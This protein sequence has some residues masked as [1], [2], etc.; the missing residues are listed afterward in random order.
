MLAI[1]KI[2]KHD[3]HIACLTSYAPPQIPMQTHKAGESTKFSQYLS[4]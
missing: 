1:L 4:F 3:V 2:L